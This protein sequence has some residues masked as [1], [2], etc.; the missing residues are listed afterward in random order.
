LSGVQLRGAQVAAARRFALFRLE[1]HSQ[2]DFGGNSGE[3]AL[4]GV[5]DR[6]HPQRVL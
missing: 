4:I 6:Q 2:I 5:P 3:I 1:R